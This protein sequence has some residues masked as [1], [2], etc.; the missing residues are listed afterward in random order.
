MEIS[1]MKRIMKIASIALVVVVAATALNGTVAHAQAATPAPT[2][3]A[4]GNR[5][6]IIKALATVLINTAATETKL[7]VADITTALDTGKTLAEV[8]QANG[9]DVATVEAAAKVTALADLKQAVTDGKVTQD[10]ADK[11]TLALDK[12]LAKLVNYPFPKGAIQGNR[13]TKLLTAAGTGLL[14]KATA[15][16]AK[17]S[18][19]D[20]L[21]E[22]RDGKTLAQ[23]ATEHN[24]D[25]NQI[26]SSTVTDATDRINKQV[27]AG[28]IKDA[29]A[30][31]LI[32]ALPGG[33]TKIMNTVNPLMN[34][35]K[36][37]GGGAGAN[38]PAQGGTPSAPIPDAVS[39]P[40]L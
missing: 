26:V 16:A 1:I 12:A 18:Q 35:N 34:L 27:T 24:A 33:L 4:A 5:G 2:P 20:L 11:L 21:Q 40:S 9:A 30:K 15:D 28:K 7:T 6:Q 23:I 36:G 39:T 37:K 3:A 31:I 10:Q 29:D 38:A 25:V 22:L 14:V 13:V 19:R 32:A 17:I 8:I